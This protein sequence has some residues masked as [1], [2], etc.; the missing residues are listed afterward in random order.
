MD[1]LDVLRSLLDIGIVAFLSYK[2]IMVVQGTKA[3][4]ILKGTGVVLFVWLISGF[5]GLETLKFIISQ[6]ILYGILGMIIIFQPELRNALENLGRNK[7]L[8]RFQVEK[9][10]MIGEKS[11]SNILDSIS[12]MSKRNIGALISIQ[13]ED[14]LEE[15]IRTGIRLKAEMSKELLINI[16]TPNVPLHDGALIIRDGILESASC[17]L[18]LSESSTIS[19]ELGT[20]HR[21]AIGLSEK[22]DALT[23]I[24]S[25]ETGAIS[26]C[27][28]SKLY[29]GISLEELKHHLEMILLKSDDSKS[30]SKIKSNKTSFLRRKLL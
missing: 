1:F 18:P 23:L 14:S 3:V 6:L 7:I 27:R 28:N 21:A 20:R 11:I 10:K 2:A 4:Q 26:M 24:V 8:Y 17:Y 5:L 16:F 25:E 15:Y 13:M 30:K 19:K 12:Y 22:T 29:R 9:E